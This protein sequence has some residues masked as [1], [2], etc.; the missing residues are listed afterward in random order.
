MRQT[1]VKCGDEVGEMEVVVI[2]SKSVGQSS[3]RF[4]TAFWN[5]RALLPVRELSVHP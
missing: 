1:S 2:A 4:P 5:R 3:Y